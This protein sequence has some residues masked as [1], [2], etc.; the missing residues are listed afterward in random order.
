MMGPGRSHLPGPKGIGEIPEFC[1]HSPWSPILFFTP[2]LN[3]FG[4]TYH[5]SSFPEHQSLSMTLQKLSFTSLALQVGTLGNA[6]LDVLP[7]SSHL[8]FVAEAS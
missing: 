3:S 2:P 7:R 5:A 6:L 8:L 4:L 1:H